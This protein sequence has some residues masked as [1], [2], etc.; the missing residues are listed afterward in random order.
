MV[1]ALLRSV[2][3]LCLGLFPGVAV[4]VCGE[5]GEA[6]L[7]ANLLLAL[8]FPVGLAIGGLWSAHYLMTPRRSLP[9]PGAEWTGWQGTVRELSMLVML[10]FCVACCAEWWDVKAEYVESHGRV[11]D[12][13][14]RLEI[15]WW[16]GIVA[17]VL[18]TLWLYSCINVMRARRIAVD[19]PG[20]VSVLLP[21][22]RWLSI[23]GVA[24]LVGAGAW[25]FIGFCVMFPLFM[26]FDGSSTAGRLGNVFDILYSAIAVL[27]GVLAG[28]KVY[29]VTQP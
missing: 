10:V 16:S 12:F 3:P 6:D 2:S 9:I 7:V 11:P 29:L 25:A 1:G 28:T 15:A 19:E 26:D 13:Y 23:V 22:E 18:G 5:T 21:V 4:V 27:A 14:L 17:I 20:G 8:G 24:T